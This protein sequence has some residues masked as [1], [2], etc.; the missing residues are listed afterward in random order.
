V[1]L[2]TTLLNLLDRAYQEEQAFVEGLSDEERSTVGTLEQW[3]AK[4]V[5]AHIAAWKERMA[6][7]LAAVARG[8]PVSRVDDYDQ[9]NA[10]IFDEYHEPPVG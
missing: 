9:V 3:S 5:I 6:R 4:D 7:N 2:R 10:E 1:D 8:E